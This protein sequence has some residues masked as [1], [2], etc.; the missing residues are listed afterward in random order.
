MTE[1]EARKKWCPFARVLITGGDD[2]NITMTSA[3]RIPYH[4]SKGAESCIA[5]ECM[6]WRYNKN[7]VDD[8]RG[9]C[10]L[11]GKP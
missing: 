8:D 6:A 4:S 9:Y 3:N 1:E 7:N 10:G 2:E 5:S 11:V